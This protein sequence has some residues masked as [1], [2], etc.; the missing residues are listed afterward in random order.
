MG[1]GKLYLREIREDKLLLSCR[2]VT[3]IKLKLR[4]CKNQS[5][6]YFVLSR[7]DSVSA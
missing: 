1:I 7:P 3:K 6:C 4:L 2:V 5:F